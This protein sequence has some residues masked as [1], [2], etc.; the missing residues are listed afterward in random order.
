MN[1][2]LNNYI[3][4]YDELFYNKNN[5]KDKF[6]VLNLPYFSYIYLF[7]SLILDTI[8]DFNKKA[9]FDDIELSTK[10]IQT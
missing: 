6:Y 5:S 3:K 9:L 2:L 1:E 10:D 7:N 8:I 4:L